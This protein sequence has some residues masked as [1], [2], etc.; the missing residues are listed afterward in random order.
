MAFYTMAFFGTAP[1]GSLLAGVAAD[2]IGARV[3]DRRRRRGVCIAAGL[4]LASRLPA[5][6]AIVRPIYIERGI[7]PVPA[8]DSGS[9]DALTATEAGHQRRLGTGNWKLANS[10]T[11]SPA[12][13]NWQLTTGNWRLATGYWQLATG[14]W[15]LAT[16][17]WRLAT[18]DWRLAT[19]QRAAS[20]PGSSLST[21]IAGN[22]LARSATASSTTTT[23]TN[24]TGSVGFTP[25][26]NDPSVACRQA[27]RRS[28]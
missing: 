10:A 5:L 19:I 3:D 25:Q 8:V 18:G 28:R 12:T 11:H 1:I 24:V 17:N 2:R 13:G 20:S 14:N 9:E 21:L 23:A 26:M 15:R 6:R 7:L 4:W 27:R 22:T 16:G